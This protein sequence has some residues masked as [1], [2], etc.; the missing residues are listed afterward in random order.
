[1]TRRW[2][3]PIGRVLYIGNPALFAR[4][5]DSWRLSLCLRMRVQCLVS[6]AEEL[7]GF[8]LSGTRVI[9]REVPSLVKPASGSLATTRIKPLYSLPLLIG[10]KLH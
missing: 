10:Y 2:F 4:S 1:M 3:E 9:K 8:S 7:A 5:L 6:N